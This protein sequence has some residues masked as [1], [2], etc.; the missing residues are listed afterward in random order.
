MH[1]RRIG[2]D[3]FIRNSVLI[4]SR[5]VRSVSLV[6]IEELYLFQK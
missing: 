3:A 1:G 5:R 6:V 2:F 4:R